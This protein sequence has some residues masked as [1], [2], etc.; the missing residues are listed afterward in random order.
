[1]SALR[2]EVNRLEEQKQARRADLLQ[3]L[4]VQLGLDSI[5][6]LIHQ[7]AVYA[8]PGLKAAVAA[9]QAGQRTPR[10]YRA[11]RLTPEAKAKII[12]ALKGG[13]KG[14]DLAREFNISHPMIQ[15]LKKGDG[16]VLNGA[17]NAKAAVLNQ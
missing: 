10:P 8:S 15:Y 11:G 12:A 14:T 2:A 17:G 9:A 16:L 4:P 1:M 7:L 6:D 5:D 3:A 13:R